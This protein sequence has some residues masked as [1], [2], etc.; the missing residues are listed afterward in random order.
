MWLDGG[1]WLGVFGVE[2]ELLHGACSRPS[3]LA[4]FFAAV[5]SV[6]Y[7][8]FKTNKDIMDALV[9]GRKKWRWRAGANNRWRASPGDVAVRHILR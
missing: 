2:R 8:R 6:A 1:V 3:W 4:Y 9:H 7:T 5:I